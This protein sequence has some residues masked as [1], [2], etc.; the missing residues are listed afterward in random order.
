MSF[1]QATNVHVHVLIPVWDARMFEGVAIV[2]TNARKSPTLENQRKL[3]PP[4]QSWT[5]RHYLL[6]LMM[7]IRN[8]I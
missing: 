3:T 5:I 4:S 2:K 8:L 7:M 6:T 1:V